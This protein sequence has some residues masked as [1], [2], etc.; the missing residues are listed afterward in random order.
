MLIESVADSLILRGALL[1]RLGG[2]L[3]VLHC[4]ALS[5]LHCRT[6]LLTSHLYI[7]SMFN[8]LNVLTGSSF[9]LKLIS[10]LDI[11]CDLPQWW[12]CTPAQSPWSTPCPPPS[13][14]GLTVQART[15]TSIDEI[16]KIM[17]YPQ[18]SIALSTVCD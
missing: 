7:S 16:L 14:S 8:M 17:T 10:A 6:L 2:A 3:G 13:E 4:R 15:Q 18:Y 11:Q 9:A 5:V 1:L 12:W